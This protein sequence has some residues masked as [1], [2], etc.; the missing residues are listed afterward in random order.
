VAD[1]EQQHDQE[2]TRWFDEHGFPPGSTDSRAHVR[3]TLAKAAEVTPAD[4]QAM[5]T[6]VLEWARSAS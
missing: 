6:F 3:V 1:V 2:T 5:D 4:R